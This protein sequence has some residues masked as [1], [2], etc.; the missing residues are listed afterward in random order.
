MLFVFGV[1]LY[2]KNIQKLKY[3]I[4]QKFKRFAQIEIECKDQIIKKC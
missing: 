4:L 3:W 1:Q 2:P